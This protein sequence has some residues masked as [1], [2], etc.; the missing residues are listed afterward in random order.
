MDRYADYLVVQTLTIAMEH[1]LP[2]ILN[3]LEDLLSPRGIIVRN[4]SPMLAAEGIEPSVRWRAGRSRNPSPQAA[5]A[6]NS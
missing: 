5:A 3:V 1:R 6:C 2:I 4:D